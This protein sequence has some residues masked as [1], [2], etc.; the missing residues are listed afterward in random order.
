MYIYSALNK[1]YVWCWGSNQGPTHTKLALYHY[2]FFT[3]L[4]LPLIDTVKNSRDN[5]MIKSSVWERERLL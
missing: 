2:T 3:F 1:F 5:A 4:V